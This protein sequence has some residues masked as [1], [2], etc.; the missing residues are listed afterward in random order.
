[1]ART[2]MRD[3]LLS[4]GFNE[5]RTARMSVLAWHREDGT[6]HNLFTHIRHRRAGGT[7][8]WAAEPDRVWRPTTFPPNDIVEPGEIQ[9]HVLDGTLEH[10]VALLEDISDG[11]A[12]T[13]DGIEVGYA[14]E[15]RPRRHRAYRN[16]MQMDE[17][18]VYSPFS[19][20]S[21]QVTEF[22][23]FETEL[24][25][26][27]REVCGSYSPRQLEEYLRRLAFPL[28]RLSDRVGNLMISGAEDEIVC[29]LVSGRT[30]LILDVTTADGTHLPP[31]A[32]YATVWAHDSGDVLVHPHLE[33]AERHTVID[34][35]SK[36]D[37]VGFAVFRRRD[38]QCIDRWEATFIREINFALNV[39]SGETLEIHDRRRGTSKTLS[40]GDAR[41]TF[42]VGDEYASGLDDAVRQE[43]LGRRSWQR[44]K[45]AR[46][47]GTMAALVRTGSSRQSTISS[48]SC[49]ISGART[50]RSTWPTPTSCTGTSTTRTS[51]FTSVCLKG[52]GASS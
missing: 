6:V 17:P 28:G 49:P 29:D 18:S 25:N 20:H 46:A 36:L 38:G 14:F 51:E 41:S 50:D 26:R 39:S 35:G 33:I 47:E 22:W 32:Y 24:R 15:Q 16:E 13:I 4:E 42:S 11:N 9:L 43:V 48:V 10:C 27:W 12:I 23:S 8:P 34:I 30:Q 7:G 44:D 31:S 1:M 37:R 3:V 2:N 45:D 52:P 40:L 19:R 5:N 21:A